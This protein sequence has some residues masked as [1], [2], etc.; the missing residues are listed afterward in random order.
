LQRHTRACEM[1]K[2]YLCILVALVG[3]LNALQVGKLTLPSETDEMANDFIWG[4]TFFDYDDDSE[5]DYYEQ[6]L[7]DEG[8]IDAEVV[9]DG[10]VDV[11]WK[12][13]SSKNY[14]ADTQ[15]A[16]TFFVISE[17]DEELTDV[18]VKIETEEEDLLTVELRGDAGSVGFFDDLDDDYEYDDY[19]NYYNDY[20]A[21]ND[22]SLEVEYYCNK[23]GRATIYITIEYKTG[24]REDN[25]VT[26]FWNKECGAGKR[27]YFKITELEN[28]KVVVSDGATTQ[29]WQDASLNVDPAEL[30]T[31][32]FQLSISDPNGG[33]QEYYQPTFEVSDE[34]IL[35]VVPVDYGSEQNVVRPYD[36]HD[37]I[38]CYLCLAAGTVTV[39]ATYVLGSYEPV[40]FTWTKVCGEGSPLGGAQLEISLSK[41][42][43]GEAQYVYKNGLVSERFSFKTAH[44]KNLF[45]LKGNQTNFDLWMHTPEGKVAVKPIVTTHP[46]N[47]LAAR[48][49]LGDSGNNQLIVDSTPR[50][51]H[52]TFRCKHKGQ[53]RVR[54]V[55]IDPT[56]RKPVKFEFFKFCSKIQKKIVPETERRMT[57]NQGLFIF[58]FSCLF[59]GVVV[60]VTYRRYK[61]RKQLEEDAKQSR[62]DNGEEEF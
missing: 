27:K 1:I 17:D 35:E 2:T 4:P 47:M 26:F 43:F 28:E 21:A 53:G 62:I 15:E 24:R 58:V 11:N 48:V 34:S 7:F 60:F 23:P 50:P 61:K 12:T 9:V 19:E 42:I 40:S 54:T 39:K 37:L 18:T 32:G 22:Y 30:E 45:K 59:V 8:W 3:S 5:I 33:S 25:S 31:K 46:K 55:F 16:Y 13:K 56:S 29:E 52:Y 41:N 51:L 49:D 57:A 10:N 20:E 38:V 36:S 44:K 14:L 6:L